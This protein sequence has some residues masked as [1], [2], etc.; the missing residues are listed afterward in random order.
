MSSQQPERRKFTRV[1]FNTGATLR[2]GD[3]SYHATLVDISLNGLLVK[4]PDDYGFNTE[5]RIEASII[6]SDDEEIQ[7][8]LE[9]VHSSNKMLGF[10]CVSIDITS[11]THLR[12]LIELNMSEPAA[13]ERV[14]S[15]LLELHG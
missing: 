14:L 4:T 2:Q 13:S 1:D 3:T 9:L 11:I 15:E 6:L 10:R 7:M 12:R 5:K 8:H